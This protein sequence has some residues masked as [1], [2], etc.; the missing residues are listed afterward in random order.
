MNDR[1]TIT[2]ARR[3]II[4]ALAMAS[5]LAGGV[6]NANPLPG[7]IFTTDS[8]CSGVD[9]NIYASKERRGHTRRLTDLH[10]LG[11]KDKA[12]PVPKI[13]VICG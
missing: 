3:A 6:V 1:K 8:T 10:R 2:F 12:I 7:A 13:C 11:F 5:L 9:L 4:A